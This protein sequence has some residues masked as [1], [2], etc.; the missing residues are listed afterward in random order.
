MK[1]NISKKGNVIV[2]GDNDGID[3]EDSGIPL[4]SLGGGDVIGPN[5][6]VDN[7][8]VLFNGTTGKLIKDSGLPLPTV[9]PLK[10]ASYGIDFISSTGIGGYIENIASPNPS[11][12]HDFAFIF[13]SPYGNPVISTPTEGWVLESGNYFIILDIR[14]RWDDVA[15]GNHIIDGDQFEVS[16]IN[17]NP[18]GPPTMD[19]FRLQNGLFNI[20][21]AQ[22]TIN[23]NYYLILPV[24]VGN[25]NV[26]QVD[27]RWTSANPNSEFYQLISSV[28][29]ITRS[30]ITFIKLGEL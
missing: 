13:G 22:P 6:S 30:S 1:E 26:F 25:S 9:F 21:I 15:G 10:T 18:P 20:G 17:A 23:L 24:R 2:S 14:I 16:I 27:I 11:H 3:I 8:V 4:S 29:G 12:I 5:S 19:S 7:N 28:P